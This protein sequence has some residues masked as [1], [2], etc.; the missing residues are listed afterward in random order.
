MFGVQLSDFD[1]HLYS[2]GKHLH[3]WRFLGSHVHVAD[4]VE[5]LRFAVWAPNARAV[6]VVGNFNAWDGTCHPMHRHPGGVWELF[7]PGLGAG[8]IYKY[9]VRG[10]DGGSLHLKSDPYGR[11]FEVRPDTATVAVREG[12]HVWGD[13]PW[14]AARR[15][16]DW[17]GRPISIYEVHLGSWQRGAEGGFLGYRELAP[18]LANHALTLG[19][20]H[21]ELLPITE[22][23]FDGS[24]GY[25]CTG[26]FAPTSRFGTPDDFRWFV[27]HLHQRGLGV[28]LDW[29]PAHFPKDRHALARF[30]GTALF[31]HA[32]PRQGEHLDWSTY[33]FN[34]GR[35]EVKSF[36]IS[37]ALYWVREFHIDGLR[38]D[39]V[40]S[41]LYLDYS[42]KEWIPNRHGGRENLEAIAFLRELNEA[43]HREGEGAL[44]MA[45]ESTS[46]PQ[47]TRPP[48]V[49]GLGFHIK[50]K[51]GW[52]NDTLD[53]LRRDPV[54]RRYHHDKLIFS[55][56]YAWSENFV[57]P[58]SHDEVVHGKGA[59]P[60]KMP[61]DR[62]QRFANLRALYAY[63]FTHPGKKLLFMGLE[64][65]Q[66][67]EWREAGALDWPGAGP[68]Q[69]L[70]QGMMRLVGDLNRLYVSEPALHRHD[71]SPEGF[72]WLDSHDAD[73]SVISHVR[74]AG[75]EHLV[76]VINFTPLVRHGYRVALPREGRYREIFNSDSSYYGGSNV[77]NGVGDIPSQAHAWCGRP[78]SLQ[79]EVPPLGA[80]VMKWMPGPLWVEPPL[81]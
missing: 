63:M 5:G 39:A 9:K 35:H 28:I 12:G 64:F 60:Q 8:E 61:G 46:W 55:I 10:A 43:V 49:G 41:M 37:S 15:R 19:F 21:V 67:S 51:M 79:L 13:G 71:F 81:G 6:S 52:M 36:L 30:D 29:V 65:G 14:M 42:R 20:T 68:E 34:Y 74:R 4:G 66:E 70:Q 45:E 22:H 57:L 77:G 50:W 69:A 38:V 58:L 24:W 23:P 56:H 27:D 26:Y 75:E 48:Q 78:H 1:L 53:Y 16:F 44:M 18:R 76:V 47:V 59:M 11:R 72:Q 33:I 40:A 2:E 80:V 73:G 3:A 54:Y 25:Q 17:M 7:V 32:D 31:E 62:W